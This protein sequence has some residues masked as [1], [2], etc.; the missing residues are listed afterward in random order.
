MKL[1]LTTEQ[2]IKK[3]ITIH[4]DRFN[5]SKVIYS[6]R[7]NKVCIICPVHGEFWQRP[8]HHLGGHSCA[9]CRSDKITILRR[10]STE[11]FIK[12]AIEIHGYFYDYSKVNY[13]SAHEKVCIICPDHGEFFQSLA[14]HINQKQ[15]CPVC[16]ASKGELAI[17]VIL[18]K[19]NIKYIREYMLPEIVSLLKYDFYLPDYN[20]L[21]EFHGGQH[22]NF[23]PYFHKT[24]D[25]F[26]KQKERD[27]F[28]KDYAYRFKYK[29][30]EFNYKQLRHMNQHQFEKLVL[31]K[32]K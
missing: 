2:F 17:K 18:D 12:R 20:L 9:K 30:L 19:H 7:K 21:I 10:L 31:D 29:F 25:N 28:K 26:L 8:D 22:Y 14:N 11:E 4:G 3:A 1:F 5:Y 16:K 6:G 13:N 24:E 23:I 32:I 27:I 15:G